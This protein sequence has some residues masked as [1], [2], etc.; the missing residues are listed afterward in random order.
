MT[1]NEFKNNKEFKDK[2]FQD[3]VETARKMG[4]P[5]PDEKMQELIFK[6]VTKDIYNKQKEAFEFVD[7]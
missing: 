1:M 5:I 4:E 2:F 7:C 6:Q 3:A